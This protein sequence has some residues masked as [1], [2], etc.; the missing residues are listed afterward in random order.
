MSVNRSN[1]SQVVHQDDI[2]NLNDVNEPNVNDPNLVGGVG[3]IHLPPSEGNGVFHITSTMLQLLQLKQLFGG[4]AYEDPH[5]HIRNFVDVCKSFFIKN[6]SQEAVRLRLFPFSLMGEACKWLVELPRDSFNSW[7]ELITAFQVRFLT[8]SKM[9]TLRDNIQNFK[10]LEGKPIH[11]T[12]LRFKKLVLQCPTDGLPDNVL[13]QYFY[14]CLDL[15]KKGVVDQHSPGGLMQ[16]P[17]V[18]ATQL[19]VVMT[20]IN[21]TWYTREDQVSPLTFKLTKEQLE[22]DHERDQNMAKMMTLLDILAK[23]VIGAGVRSVNVVGVGC[24]NLDEAKFELLYNEEVKFLVNQGG[25]YHANYLRLGGNQGWNRDEG[26]SDLDRE[27]RDHNATWKER[28]G[29]K[30]RY[31]PPHECQKPKDSEGGRTEDML[32]PI[33]NKVKGSDKVLK[34]MKEDVLTLNQ[35]VASHSISIKQLDTQMGQITSHLNPRQLGELPSDIMANP[36][37]EV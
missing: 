25:G 4:L 10:R 11:E 19:L 31:V 13:L 14:I 5:E 26:W 2:E 6:I 17:Y 21:R 22:K 18:I 34:E 27:W 23:N 9:M 29:E 20:K 8:P 12:W 28:E 30:D 24:V 37:N 7:D 32:S 36:K 35:T 15:V 3:A 33:L 16:Q 1:S